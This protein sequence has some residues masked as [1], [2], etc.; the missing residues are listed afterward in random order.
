MRKVNA[1]GFE[2]VVILSSIWFPICVYSY[3]DKGDLSTIGIVKAKDMLTN[4]IKYY[5]GVG[6][7]KNQ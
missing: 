4:T 1:V 3:A 2:N 7:G 6:K 5:I